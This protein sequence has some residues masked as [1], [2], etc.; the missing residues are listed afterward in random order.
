MCASC[1]PA[2]QIVADDGLA[3]AQVAAAAVV[4]FG[5][6]TTPGPDAGLGLVPTRRNRGLLERAAF[7]A[8]SSSPRCRSIGR[9]GISRVFEH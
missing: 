3:G 1:C 6:A 5:A 2:E 4:R 8:R 9:R 7:G